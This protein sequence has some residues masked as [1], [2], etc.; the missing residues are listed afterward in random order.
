M[1]DEFLIKS[2]ASSSCSTSDRNNEENLY[3]SWM[4][5]QNQELNELQNAATL[6]RKNQKTDTELNQLLARM[7]NNFQGYVNGRSRLARVDISPYFAPTWCTPL[8]NSVLWIG[9]CRPSSFIRPI[10]ALC[11]MEIESHLTEFLQGMEISDFGQLSGKQIMLIDKL[12]RKSIV[13]ERKLSS[14]LASLQEDVVD[15]PIITAANN[16]E[17]EEE[18]L[19]KHGQGM[20]TLL[21]EADELRM[22][23]LKEILGILT[24]IQGVEYLASAKRIR[25]SLQQWGKK[26][27]QEHTNLLEIN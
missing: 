3:E 18:P 11:G 12:H 26:R 1:A 21:E 2:M 20:T 5:N 27:E 4:E 8:E 24:P 9:G 15:Q 10:Y 17:N 16:S 22:N 13:E 25:L 23:T 14:K 19:N 6:A 7:V